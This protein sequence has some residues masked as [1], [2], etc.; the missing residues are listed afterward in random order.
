MVIVDV[1]VPCAGWCLRGDDDEISRQ[2]RVPV[3]PKHEGRFGLMKHALQWLVDTWEHD[4]SLR[5]PDRLAQRIDVLDRLEEELIERV[6]QPDESGIQH[7]AAALG[8]E[9]AAINN[10]IYADI[11]AQIQQG[12]GADAWTAWLPSPLYGDVS[13]PHASDE[14]Y[15][16]LDTLLSGVLQLREPTEDV[17]APGPEMVFYQPTPARHIFDMLARV[18]LRESDV[19]IDLGAGMGHVPLLAATYTKAQCIGIELEHAYVVSAQQCADALNLSNLRFIAEDVRA[20]DFSMGTVFYLYTPFTGAIWRNVL[21]R[22]EQEAATRPI[23]LCSLGP[24]TSLMA[25]E[26]WLEAAGDVHAS[27]IAIF[28]SR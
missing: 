10:G 18:Q 1:M 27:R 3:A 4:P 28:H 21:D 15:D 24:C 9:L 5:E 16:Y 23:Q 22:L 7:R 19:L 17:A 26:R 25:A 14:S 13:E 8:H 11:R 2:A 6:D 20:A 12:R